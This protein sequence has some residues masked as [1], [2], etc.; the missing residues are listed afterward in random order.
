[1]LKQLNFNAVRTCHY[2]NDPRWYEL[3]DRYG[4]WSRG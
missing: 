4:I 3:C 2:P 1:M